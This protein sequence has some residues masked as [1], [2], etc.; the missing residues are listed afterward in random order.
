MLKGVKMNK[1]S[2]SKSKKKVQFEFDP[3]RPID[4][5]QLNA[6]LLDENKLLKQQSVLKKSKSKSK[7][8]VNSA[9]GG[10]LSFT[11]R[12]NGMGNAIRNF[13]VRRRSTDLG[14]AIRNFSVKRRVKGLAKGAI[15]GMVKTALKTLFKC[16]LM[17]LLAFP[18]PCSNI[19]GRLKE[20]AEKLSNLLK[21]N[22]DF[23][24]FM[25]K[26]KVDDIRNMT[27]DNIAKMQ[28]EVDK[29]AAYTVFHDSF[30][31]LHD[32]RKELKEIYLENSST[33][34]SDLSFS[35]FEN[36]F[37]KVVEQT[38]AFQKEI[39][40]S[41]Q[42]LQQLSD[43]V[44]SKDVTLVADNLKTLITLNE[45]VVD[46]LTS[47]YAHYEKSDFLAKENTHGDIIIGFAHSYLM[48]LISLGTGTWPLFIGNVVLSIG[49]MT[50]LQ[51]ICT[52]LFNQLPESAQNHQV[53]KLYSATVEVYLTICSYIFSFL[54]VDIEEDVTPNNVA[55]LTSKS[56]DQMISSDD[57]PL[58]DHIKH[59]QE[60]NYK[61]LEKKQN[62]LITNRESE[63]NHS[64]R[65]ILK[66][67][68][69]LERQK[70][71]S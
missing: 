11:R 2:K 65:V 6:I 54:G 9:V 42:V 38:K 25:S 23:H 59:L 68:K 49:A 28:D 37:L 30:Q 19:M 44:L 41:G 7:W 36:Q 17:T 56:V 70:K 50:M 35:A 12:V 20:H 13:S 57:K 67:L 47:P 34:D 62:K 4:L 55:D 21:S 15:R 43:A 48:T 63:L 31:D 58:D 24:D 1:L 52:K 39:L 3:L 53:V 45:I 5:E 14:H 26:F 16:F 69:E 60:K 27:L 71:N 10:G 8:K 29:N 61:Y 51:K 64:E 32:L 40:S 66:K 18:N 46:D 33:S 22:L